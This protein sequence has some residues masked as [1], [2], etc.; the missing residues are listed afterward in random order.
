MRAA[1]K[2]K[3]VAR[4][5]KISPKEP[6]N[7]GIVKKKPRPRGFFTRMSD[8]ELVEYAQKIVEK[9]R[10]KSRSELSEKDRSLYYILKRR[11]NPDGFK[12]IDIVKFEG[13]NRNWT[14]MN[15][16][17]LV[18]F[19]QE[20]VYRENLEN[21][22]RLMEIDCGL[23]TALY[24]RKDL[25]GSRLLV[26]VKFEADKRAW[27]KYSNSELIA[28]AQDYVNREGIMSRQEFYKNDSGLYGAL[29]RRN[30]KG[31]RLLDKI[32]FK[33]DERAWS[34]YSDSELIE[35]AQKYVDKERIKSRSEF[36]KKDAGLYHT[37]RMRMCSNGV[38]LI[39]KV[40]L[41]NHRKRK[42]RGFFTKMNDSELVEYAQEYVDR[43]GITSRSELDKKDSRLC[44]VLRE[45]SDSCGVRMIDK[46]LFEADVRAWSKYSDSDLVEYAQEY[47]DREGINKR[48]EM[49]R[50]DSGFYQ[51]L[52]KR[53]LLDLVFAEIEQ[54][55]VDAGLIRGLSQAADAMEQFGA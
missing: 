53:K 44:Q 48:I 18:C 51:A 7:E 14:S 26:K 25:D 47:V 54:S 30:P 24:K 2:A 42:C 10:I 16:S 21:K 1:Q 38:K 37:L 3:P 50:K 31:I 28:Y 41:K 55:K 11:I 23:Y 36:I 43:E 27:S 19:A 29:R 5:S 4:E 35:Y 22:T 15:D 32:K 46:L 12:L 6:M 20:F 45:R 17:E 33:D 9:E 52:Y 39:D 49:Y 34:K 13:G 8:S 40:K